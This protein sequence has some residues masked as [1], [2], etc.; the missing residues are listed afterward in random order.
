MISGY[1]NIRTCRNACHCRY[2]TLPMA[3][4]SVT[5][6]IE[7][8]L[9]HWDARFYNIARDSTA[10]V[11][12]DLLYIG[13]YFSYSGQN[14]AK[15]ILQ[16]GTMVSGTGT[17]DDSKPFLVTSV[18]CIQDSKQTFT[19]LPPHGK[20]RSE[21]SDK[22]KKESKDPN[23]FAFNWERGICTDF[24]Q[25]FDFVLSKPIL[26]FFSPSAPFV[27]YCFDYGKKC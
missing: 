15:S 6:N 19:P 8:Q 5:A 12:V 24:P 14:I 23:V 17:A 11:A 13:G 20:P 27:S 4:R 21:C 18:P 9:Y 3:T 2:S 26:S 1:A 7:V 16:L 25:Q 10:T 22:P